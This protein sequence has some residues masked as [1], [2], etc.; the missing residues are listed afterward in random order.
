MHRK[1]CPRYQSTLYR[2]WN[3][4]PMALPSKVGSFQGKLCAP[5]HCS[6]DDKDLNSHIALEH[7][8]GISETVFGIMGYLDIHFFTK[9]LE[10]DEDILLGW[11]AYT[12]VED[13]WTS[14]VLRGLAEELLSRHQE[15]LLTPEFIINHVLM[16]FIRPLFSST[17][18]PAITPQGRKAINASST[19]LNQQNDLDSSSKAW[20]S[21]D[22]HAMAVFEW[23]VGHMDVGSYY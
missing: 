10:I 3:S 6:A 1:F 18:T 11:L 12:N 2:Q 7:F 9:G 5:S 16:G 23:A 19:T 15:Q 22:V 4:S 13:P 8:Q 17:R 21:R 14:K 20:K